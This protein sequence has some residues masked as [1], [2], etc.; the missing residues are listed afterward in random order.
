[1][2][3]T[4]HQNA[5]NVVLGSVFL[6]DDIL[7]RWQDITLERLVKSILGRSGCPAWEE[8]AN[9]KWLSCDDR[10]QSSAEDARFIAAW[11]GCSAAAAAARCASLIVG[12]LPSRQ[13][14]LE[15]TE[16]II[17]QGIMITWP[18]YDQGNKSNAKR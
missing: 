14:A 4:G 13:Y 5:V 1:M 16:I 12:L 18:G 11:H 7:R 10:S 2:T 15:F 8:W 9:N 17:D 6:P 3:G